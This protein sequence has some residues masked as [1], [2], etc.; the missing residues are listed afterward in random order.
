MRVRVRG[1]QWHLSG[2]RASSP[3][4]ESRK[5]G[6]FAPMARELSAHTR[7]RQTKSINRSGSTFCTDASFF[8]WRANQRIAPNISPS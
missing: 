7:A 4:I 6:D 8:R 3:L 2:A 1:G 5:M